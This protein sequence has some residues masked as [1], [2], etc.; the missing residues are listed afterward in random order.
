MDVLAPL[1]RVALRYLAG[2]LVARGYSI[3]P[4]TLTDP[5]IVQVICFVAGTTCALVSEG[6]WALARKHGWDQ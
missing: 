3:S 5:D 2:I 4:D 6:W 1:V